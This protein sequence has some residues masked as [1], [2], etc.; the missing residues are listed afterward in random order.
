VDQLVA[1]VAIALVLLALV[2]RDVLIDHG[3]FLRATSSERNDAMRDTAEVRTDTLR[4]GPG[5]SVEDDA[6]A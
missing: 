4:L 5:P 2:V 3:R 1:S 6:A